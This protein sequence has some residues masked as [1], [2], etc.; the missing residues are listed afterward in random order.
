M[1]RQ[2]GTD[3]RKKFAGNTTLYSDSKIYRSPVFLQRSINSVLTY[4][5]QKLLKGLGNSCSKKA[6]STCDSIPEESSSNQPRSGFWS[7]KELEA[8]IDESRLDLGQ[9]VLRIELKGI[10][11]KRERFQFSHGEPAS[12]RLKAS[13]IRAQC[14]LTIWDAKSSKQEYVVTQTKPCIIITASSSASGSLAT[15]EMDEAFSV[16]A[17]ELFSSRNAKSLPDRA[18]GTAYMMQITLL[19]TTSDDQWPPV[20]IKL[21][22]PRD[23][24]V[25]DQGETVRAPML[26]AKWLRLPECPQAGSFLTVSAY[27]DA[28]EYKTKL[29]LEIEAA[30]NIAASPLVVHNQQRKQA[31]SPKL[32][33]PSPTSDICIPKSIVTVNW[34]FVG[35]SQEDDILT[36]DGYLCPLCNKLDLKNLD[37]LHFHLINSHDL[38]KFRL[39]SDATATLARLPKV[40]VDVSVDVADDYRERAANHVPDDREMAWKKPQRL[41]DLEAFLKGDASWLGKPSRKPRLQ[42]TSRLQASSSSESRDWSKAET[43]IIKSRQPDAVP[44]LAAPNRR[45][46]RVPAAPRMVQYF[47]STPKRP[48]EEGE[49]LSESDDDIHEGWL[50]QRH[51]ETIQSFTDMSLSEKEFILRFDKH[52][53]KED[54]S[55]YLHLGEALVRFCRLNR[56]WLRRKDMGIEFHKHAAK[57]M[58]HGIVDHLLVQACVRII[59]DRNRDDSENEARDLDEHRKAASRKVRNVKQ[60]CLSNKKVSPRRRWSPKTMNRSPKQAVHELETCSCQKSI[61]D[62]RTCIRCSNVVSN[63]LTK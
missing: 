48:L 34:S 44:D 6:M 11:D 52:V 24:Q 42:I 21:P 57:L 61:Y 45:K 4:H 3:F 1:N 17:S 8:S 25:Y 47:R 22:T 13:R 37:S 60:E 59:Q 23:A 28:K 9:P 31:S 33:L 18:E 14:A 7:L 12:K 38:F 30:W 43:P 62:M 49:W 2:S 19:S 46:H 58:L 29:A 26:L 63:S 55:S 54:L 35:Q 51:E 56:K 53:L 16:R 36:Y 32:Q 5:K 20:P 40:A 27:Q 15:I 10:K 39:K 50:L 41:F